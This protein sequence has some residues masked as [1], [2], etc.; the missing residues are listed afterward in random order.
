MPNKAFAMRKLI[1]SALCVV[2]AAL[3]QWVDV[4]EAARVVMPGEVDSNSPAFWKDGELHVIN[5]TGLG[6]LV[7]HGPDQFQLSDAKLSTI[8]RPQKDWPT[9]IE[10]VWVDPSG[11]ILAWYHQEHE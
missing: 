4:R 8:I 5:S 6:P 3:P 2:T 11:T 1:L 10:A 9:W 7:S